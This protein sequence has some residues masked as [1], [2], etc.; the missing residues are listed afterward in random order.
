M[1][2]EKSAEALMGGWCDRHSRYRARK[3]M[4]GRCIMDSL[5]AMLEEGRSLERADI[6][7]RL[8]VDLSKKRDTYTK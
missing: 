6:G 3:M 5:Q 1:T 4:C 2:P 8:G 7:A